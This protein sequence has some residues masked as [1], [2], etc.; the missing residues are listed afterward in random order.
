MKSLSTTAPLSFDQLCCFWTPRRAWC[1]CAASRIEDIARISIA[2]PSSTWHCQSRTR[3]H[4]GLYGWTKGACTVLGILMS[5]SIGLRTLLNKT[6]SCYSLISTWNRWASQTLS[7]NVSI[8]QY[9]YQSMFVSINVSLPGTPVL[10]ACLF[11]VFCYC[12][13]WLD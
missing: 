2:A 7:I 3:C 6:T 5:S 8:N 1:L 9:F 4:P 11:R 10:F 13:V 12:K